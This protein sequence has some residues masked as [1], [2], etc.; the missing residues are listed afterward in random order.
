MKY[1][2][3]REMGRNDDDDDDDDEGEERREKESVMK[4][5]S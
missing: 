4:L 3:N 1:S 2:R 5:R